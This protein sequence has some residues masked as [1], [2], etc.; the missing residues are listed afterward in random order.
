MAASSVVLLLL[1]HCHCPLLGRVAT[2]RCISFIVATTI[3]HR[4]RLLWSGL[5]WRLFLLGFFLVEVPILNFRGSQVGDPDQV[6]RKKYYFQSRIVRI[7]RA[8]FTDENRPNRDFFDFFLLPRAY[9]QY[10]CPYTFFST[11][12]LFVSQRVRPKTLEFSP[13]FFSRENGATKYWVSWQSGSD[14]VTRRKMYCRIR[15]S[16]RLMLLDLH[17]PFL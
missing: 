7:D 11:A 8:K 2:M 6:A 9:K 16:R 14:D 3:V 15:F 4:S 13:I 5:V 10:S 1:L 17:N 12:A